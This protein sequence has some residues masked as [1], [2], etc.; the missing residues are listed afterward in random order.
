MEPW[1]IMH[2]LKFTPQAEEGGKVRQWIFPILGSTSQGLLIM[3]FLILQMAHRAPH[4]T[5]EKL[6]LI[7]RGQM[8]LFI[9]LPQDPFAH[10][11]SWSLFLNS[12]CPHSVLSGGLYNLSLF[13]VLPIGSL[14][15]PLFF[16]NLKLAIENTVD[17]W[18][19]ERKAESP[20]TAATALYRGQEDG[21][22]GETV[23]KTTVACFYL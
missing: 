12:D 16:I 22:V 2:H 10:R 5:S 23:G 13:P 15:W 11:H 20:G 7:R 14:G 21:T 17:P 9:Y 8:S 4:P 19:W 1:L 18:R 3:G 6:E